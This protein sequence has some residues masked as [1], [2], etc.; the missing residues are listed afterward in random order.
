MV[1]YDFRNFADTAA[2]RRGIHTRRGVRCSAAYGAATPRCAL[3]ITLIFRL[4]FIIFAAAH[5]AIRITPPRLML[6]SACR[7]SRADGAPLPRLPPRCRAS[8]FS[9]RLL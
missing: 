1:R 7:L 9:C 4:V 6:M 5:I 3:I 8:F 2:D